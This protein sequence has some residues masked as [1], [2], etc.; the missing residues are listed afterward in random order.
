MNRVT[1]RGQC[2]AMAVLSLL[3]PMGCGGGDNGAP[4]PAGSGGAGGSGGSGGMSVLVDAGEG[5]ATVH[6]IE[7]TPFGAH[8]FPYPATGIKPTGDQAA[9]DKVATGYYDL[10]KAAY[11]K[12]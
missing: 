3:I 12:E 4:A 6:P 9:L 2:S 10:W 1:T 8:Q 11:L 5:T 7:G